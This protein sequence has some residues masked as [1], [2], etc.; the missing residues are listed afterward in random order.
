MKFVGASYEDAYA[1]AAAFVGQAEQWCDTYRAPLEAS[2][3]VLDFGVGW[4]R[5]SRMLLTRIAPTRLFGLDVDDDMVAL[6]QQTLPG[7]SVCVVEPQPPS[8]LREGLIQHAFAFSVFSH[9]AEEPHRQWAAEFGRL[10][11][12]GGMVFIT[13]LDQVFLHQIRQCRENVR[14]GSTDSFTTSLAGLI[15]DLDGASASFERGAF[16]YAA[17][18]VEDGPRTTDYYGW[19][20]APRDWVSGVWGTA[21][22]EVLEWVDSHVLFPQAMVCLRR[23]AQTRAG[24]SWTDVFTRRAARL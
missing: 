18:D 5:I 17:P 21:G 4:G 23:T 13:V 7:V 15:P 19:A 9:L 3:G 24:R 10:V 11:E 6:V 16:I 1:E 12:P 8:P 2:A 20:V 22:F 14:E